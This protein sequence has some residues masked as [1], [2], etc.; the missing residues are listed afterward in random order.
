MSASDKSGQSQTPPDYDEE[1]T[2]AVDKF[3]E[4]HK[5]PADDAVLL[6][7]ELFRIAAPIQIK[8]VSAMLDLFR[9]RIMFAVKAL[10]VLIFVMFHILSVLFFDVVFSTLWPP[11]HP[12]NI[13]C[14]CSDHVVESRNPG[15]AEIPPCIPVI[16]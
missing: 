3:R 11:L 10:S 8:L 13:P 14:D 2:Q 6:L 16:V 12:P 4:Q 7:V 5:L 15:S 9:I 1:F